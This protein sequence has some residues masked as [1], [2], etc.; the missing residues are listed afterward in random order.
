MIVRLAAGMGNQLFQW[1]FGRCVS[2]KRGEEL[3]FE[4]HDLDAGHPRAYSLGAFGLDLKFAEPNGAP[5][6]IETHE[7]FGF[8][9]EV[10]KVPNG[11]HFIGNWQTEKYLNRDLVL[12]NLGWHT[13]PSPQTVSV[14]HEILSSSETAFVHVRR[15]DYLIPS[16]VAYHGNVS[17]EYYAAAMEFIRSRYPHVRFYI[18]SDDPGWSYENFP[19]CRVVDHN[20]PGSGETGPGREHEDLHLMSLC[21]HAIIPNSSFG[22]WAAWLRRDKDRP[23]CYTI[24]PKVWFRKEGLRYTDV[25]PERWIQM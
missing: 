20:K 24:A 4:K 14:A 2:L 10:Y 21:K 16:T 13:Q 25:V 8:D 7:K 18:F 19:G 17:R 3:F 15:T 12:E 6:F 1:A 5:Q 9:P 11:T 22:W 23:G